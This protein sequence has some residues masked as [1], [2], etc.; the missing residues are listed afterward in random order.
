[1]GVPIGAPEL[2]FTTYA[3]EPA[4]AVDSPGIASPRANF[5]G[6]AGT[7]MELYLTA[8]QDTYCVARDTVTVRV[9]DCIHPWLPNAITPNGDGDNNAF[10]IYNLPPG[11]R[12]TVLDRNGHVLFDTP[13]YQNDWSP[14]PEVPEGVYLVRLEIPD[15]ESMVGWVTV[16]R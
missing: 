5:P 13:D 14:G 1:V 4:W 3:W 12:F 10:Y 7:E 16:L 6:W 15:R 9:D 2:P 11:C 8:I